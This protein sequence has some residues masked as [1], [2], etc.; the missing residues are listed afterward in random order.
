M[1]LLCCAVVASGCSFF[2]PQGVPTVIVVPGGDQPTSTLD[3][4]ISMTPRF[5]A[6]LEPTLTP[7]PTETLTPTMTVPPATNTT[8][9]TITPTPATRA[10]VNFTSP[11]VNMRS[12][13][14][15]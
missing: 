13:P 12:G 15:Q 11:T 8:T 9:P 1:L 7:I 2:K 4:I 5:T 3:G 6:T 10:S 14:G